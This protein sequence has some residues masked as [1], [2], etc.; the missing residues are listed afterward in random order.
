MT[1]KRFFD[2]RTSGGTDD[3]MRLVDATIRLR[4]SGYG[5]TG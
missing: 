3:A 2:W 5:V 4:P 1:A